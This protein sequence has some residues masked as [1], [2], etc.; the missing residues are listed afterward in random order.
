MSRNCNFVRC[1]TGQEDFVSKTSLAIPLYA[2][3]GDLSARK[4]QGWTVEGDVGQ[5]AYGV[6]RKAFEVK[7][8]PVLWGLL[9]VEL[10]GRKK[11]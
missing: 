11:D 8:P 10:A 2:P 1:T 3:E 5:V 7:V 4:L 6:S 9:P